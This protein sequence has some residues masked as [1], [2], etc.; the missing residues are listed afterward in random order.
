[1][2]VL[3]RPMPLAEGLP[4]RPD[5]L[6]RLLNGGSVAIRS[7]R[8]LSLRCHRSAMLGRVDISAQPGCGPPP[9]AKT[10]DSTGATLIDR[11]LGSVFRRQQPSLGAG[12]GNLGDGGDEKPALGKVAD[13]EVGTGAEEGEDFV[14]LIGRQFQVCQT[15]RVH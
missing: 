4:A 2:G 1:M 15:L 9:K 14:P 5:I 3:I 6:R 11:V 12:A 10:I 7:T 13:V 8:S